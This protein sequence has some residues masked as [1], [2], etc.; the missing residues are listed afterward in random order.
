MF[1]FLLLWQS[2]GRF[3]FDRGLHN[4]IM[5]L[6]KLHNDT[7]NNKKCKLNYYIYI[8]HLIICIYMHTHIYI[9]IDHVGKKSVSGYGDQRYNA[10]LHQC[11]VIEQDTICIASVDIA[12][13]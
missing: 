1:S 11:F 13:K 9:Y 3:N 12:D 10:S 2:V 6:K 7:T 8:W 4:L 5:L